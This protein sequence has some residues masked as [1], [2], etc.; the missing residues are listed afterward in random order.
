MKK[1][2]TSILNQNILDESFS[3]FSSSDVIDLRDKISSTEKLI[4]DLKRQLLGNLSIPAKISIKEKV[5]SLEKDLT[6]YKSQLSSI[7]KSRGII[8]TF[9]L[10]LFLISSNLSVLLATN[11]KS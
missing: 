6:S 8:L 1:L 9:V 4:N 5:V 10:I 11:I 3:N 7:P 2:D